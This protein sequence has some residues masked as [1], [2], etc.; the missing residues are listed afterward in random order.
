MLN[1]SNQ[2]NVVTNLQQI[3]S[4]PI[5]WSRSAYNSTTGAMEA[6]QQPQQQQQPVDYGQVEYE[7]RRDSRSTSSSRAGSRS[8]SKP[9]S[10]PMS[11][12]SSQQRFYDEQ[13]DYGQ[14]QQQQPRSLSR[15]DSQRSLTDYQ[16][17]RQPDPLITTRIEE[18]Y[19]EPGMEVRKPSVT[20]KN[21]EYEQQQ[22][23]QFQSQDDLQQVVEQR[24][25]LYASQQQQPQQYDEQSYYQ[26]EYTTEQNMGY[27]YDQQQYIPQQQ[28]SYESEQQS[29]YYQSDSRRQSPENTYQQIQGYTDSRR[30]SPEQEYRSYVEPQTPKRTSPPKTPTREQSREEIDKI[31]QQRQQSRDQMYGGGGDYESK[32]LS[33]KQQSRDNLSEAQVKSPSPPSSQNVSPISTTA[34]TTSLTK[35]PTNTSARQVAPPSPKRGSTTRNTKGAA[36]SKT[37]RN[38]MGEATATGRKSD[39]VQKQP[40]KVSNIRGKK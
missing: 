9:P 6:Y 22:Q 19:I 14:Q 1:F 5:D 4:A 31:I 7:K 28:Q 20:F 36:E 15:N 13:N 39:N 32:A 40:S 26:P 37:G 35:G 25:P 29:R 18:S 3:D 30:Q 8:N 21:D 2:F 33:S 34:P 12:A 11:R 24:S 17:Q 10:R 38:T 27:S 16:Q 23:Q